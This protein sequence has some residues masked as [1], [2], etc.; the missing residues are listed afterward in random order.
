MISPGRT[1]ERKAD[2]RATRS[3]REVQADL[4]V[5]AMSGRAL[6]EPCAVLNQMAGLGMPASRRIT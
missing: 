5:F 3:M 4:R 2:E 1:A 6:I